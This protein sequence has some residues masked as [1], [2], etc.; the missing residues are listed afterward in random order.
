MRYVVQISWSID[1]W[2][3]SVETDQDRI[4]IKATSVIQFNQYN[5]IGQEDILT[6]EWFIID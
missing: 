2:V 5:T 3:E 4:L 6:N 1:G